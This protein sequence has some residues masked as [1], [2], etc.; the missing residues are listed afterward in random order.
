MAN[1]LKIIIVGGGTAG[2]MCA[3]ALARLLDPS[4]YSVRLV[5]SDEIGTVGVGEA[6][7]PQIRAFHAMLG[8][9]EAEFMRETGATFKLGIAFDGWAGGEGAPGEPSYIHPFGTFGARWGGVDFHQHWLRAR[10]DGRPVGPFQAYACAIEACRRGRFQFPAKDPTS[11]GAT[12][13]YAYHLDAGR[14]ARFLRRWA[15]QRN[16][17]RTEGEVVH[18]E[19]DR[20][21]GAIEALTLKSGQRLEADLFVDAS[22]FRSVLLGRVLQ[23][24]WE[25]WSAWLPCDR[26]LAAPTPHADDADAVDRPNFT[27]Y[28]RS[29][30][31]SAG[32]VWRIPLQS[33]MG[34]GYV[35]ASS[36]V[37]DEAALD[38]FTRSVPGVALAEPRRLRFS[39][40]RRRGAW[41]RNCVGIGLS[42]GFL[43]PL[44]STSIYLIQRAVECLV[45]LMPAAPGSVD[46]RLAAEFNRLMDLEYERIRDFLILHY[47]VNG[48]YGEAFWDHVRHMSVPNSLTARI[49]LFEARGYV[50]YSK[51][52]LFSRDSWLSV[53]LGQGVTPR[54][55]EPLAYA[56]GLDDLDVRMGELRDRIAQQVQAMPTHHAFLSTFGAA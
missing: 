18:A 52:G 4:R 13:S 30:A 55:A 39:A 6:T 7:L 11:P 16:V 44:E 29:I 51:D 27:P 42:S 34:N 41:T 12:Y 2:W 31:Q 46:P 20:T 15:T 50:P 38:T 23:A 45:D 47:Y 48:R 17:G 56:I 19:V 10:L 32:W 21:S 40:G 28:T 25:D 9:D 26:A 35:Y 8:V 22:G 5:E 1:G 24:A 43:E 53:L 54:A 14:Y 49:E 36:F 37:G 3:A 33:R